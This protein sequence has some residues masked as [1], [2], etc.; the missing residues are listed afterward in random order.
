MIQPT[1]GRVVWY[2]NPDEMQEDSDP[3]AAIVCGVLDSGRK[4]NLTVFGYEG[5]A[6]GHKSVLLW[7]GEGARPTVP[8]CEW[9]TYQKGQAAK[10]DELER[11]IKDGFTKP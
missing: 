2:R 1:V 3:L 7:Q 4:V 6:V 8:Y 10:V 5:G 9:M 11:A